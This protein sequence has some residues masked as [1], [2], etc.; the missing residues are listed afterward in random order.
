M[1]LGPADGFARR[2]TGLL[3]EDDPRAHVLLAEAVRPIAETI[4]T[5]WR[6]RPHAELVGIGGG[7]ATGLGDRYQAELHRQLVT[8][9][10]YSDLG[11][12][13]AW[14]ADRVRVLRPGQCDVLAGARLLAQGSLRL[15]PPTP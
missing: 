12:D 8:D 9:R 11:R 14:V 6:M 1:G 13:H 4:R 2:F 10:A 3:D 15:R 5:L 7:V